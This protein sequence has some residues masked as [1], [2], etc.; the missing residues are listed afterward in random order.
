MTPAA[1]IFDM[2]GLLLDTEQLYLTAYRT[3]RA[4]LDMAADDAPYMAMIGLN[5][6][7]TEAAMAQHFGDTARLFGA[8]WGAEISRLFQGELP[9]KPGVRTFAQHLGETGTPYAIATSTRTTSARTHLEQAGLDD[10]FQTIIGG[11][12]VQNGKPDP[13][14]YL[15]AAATLGIAASTCAAFEDSENGV[16][17]ALAAGMRVV[18]VPDLKHPD[19]DFRAMGH[20]VAETLLDGALHLG[21]VVG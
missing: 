21:F 10:L 12:Q 19:E 17:A 2:D 20:H 5:G 1:V 9:V 7:S 18:Q 15:R 6:P 16:R 14:I 11:D 3:A 4:R 8:Q 13:E